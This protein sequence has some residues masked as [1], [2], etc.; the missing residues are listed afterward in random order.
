MTPGKRFIIPENSRKAT[1]LKGRT[2]ACAARAPAGEPRMIIL[3]DDCC[4]HDGADHDLA[5]VLVDAERHDP[6]ADHLDDECPEQRSQRGAFSA[7]EARAAHD[8][9]GDDIQLI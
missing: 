4:D 7:G 6:A 1:W 9:G 5:V 8:G 2:I 3:E